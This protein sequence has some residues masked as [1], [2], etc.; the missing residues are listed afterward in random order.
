MNKSTLYSFFIFI[1]ALVLIGIVAA[2]GREG[3]GNYQLNKEISG[4]KKEIESLKKNN[5]ELSGLVDYYSSEK[6]LEGEARLKLNLVKEGEKLVI[7]SPEE[8][9][10]SGSQPLSSNGKKQ[11]SNFDKWLEYLGFDKDFQR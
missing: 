8:N 4:L 9:A 6:S 2:F 7:I 5:E 3:Y 1:L 10:A 11:F